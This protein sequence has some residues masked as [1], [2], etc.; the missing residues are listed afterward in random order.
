MKADRRRSYNTTVPTKPSEAGLLVN[1]LKQHEDAVKVVRGL[2]KEGN[3]ARWTAAIRTAVRDVFDKPTR[4]R[5][6]GSR[7]PCAGTLSH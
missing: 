3:G 5:L 6:C 4:R 2:L 7:M 1:D